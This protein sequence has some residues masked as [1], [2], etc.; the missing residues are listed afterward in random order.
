MLRQRHSLDL[1]ILLSLGVPFIL[2][3]YENPRWLHTR[4]DRIWIMFLDSRCSG[5]LN[6]ASA[7]VVNELM[8]EYFVRRPVCQSVMMTR[9]CLSMTMTMSV[10]P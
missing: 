5:M 10:T 6:I 9:T 1:C 4:Q 8:N 2:K 3:I 7:Y